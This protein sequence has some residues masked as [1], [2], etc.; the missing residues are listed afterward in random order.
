MLRPGKLVSWGKSKTLTFKISDVAICS[1]EPRALAAVGML[2]R[3]H[4]PN[5]RAAEGL[6]SHP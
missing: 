3:Y 2:R 1:G 6:V 4:L 5:S